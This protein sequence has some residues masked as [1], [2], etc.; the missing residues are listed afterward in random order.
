MCSKLKDLLNKDLINIVNLY[1][2]P[3]KN[4]MKK[5]YTN[6]VINYYPLYRASSECSSILSQYYYFIL[7]RRYGPCIDTMS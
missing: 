2:L 3:D 7:R 6:I 4:E 1:L 5:L